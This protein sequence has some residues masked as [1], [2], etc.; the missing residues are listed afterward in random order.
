METPAELPRDRIHDGAWVEKGEPD[1]RCG[2][3]STS[4]IAVRVLRANLFGCM[5]ANGCAAQTR[6]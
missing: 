4:E 1:R 3:G 6:I 2:G 5:L